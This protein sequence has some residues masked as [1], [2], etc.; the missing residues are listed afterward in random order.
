MR[1]RGME[2][3]KETGRKRAFAKGHD[4][5]D[6]GPCRADQNAICVVS[7]V[8]RL[9]MKNKKKRMLDH[10]DQNASQATRYCRPDETTQSSSLSL[11][12][13]CKNSQNSQVSYPKIYPSTP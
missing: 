13:P 6:I 5:I 3:T 8:C 10:T 12:L 11:F 1:S 9:T 7:Q 2:V 4:E